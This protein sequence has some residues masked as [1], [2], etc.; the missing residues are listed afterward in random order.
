MKTKQGTKSKF[1]SSS[2]YV[3]MQSYQILNVLNRYNGFKTKRERKTEENK[4]KNNLENKLD[5]L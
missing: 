4:K 5:Q 3:Y 2:N 1:L